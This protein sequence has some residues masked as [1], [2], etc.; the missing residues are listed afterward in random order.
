VPSNVFRIVIFT[1]ASPSDLRHFLWRLRVDLPDVDVAGVLYETGRPSL[2][3]SRRLERAR[4]HLGDVDFLRYTASRA[5][6]G[7]PRPPAPP[8]ARAGC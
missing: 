7:P 4:R 2:P 5:T 6:G 3:L 8:A 1:S